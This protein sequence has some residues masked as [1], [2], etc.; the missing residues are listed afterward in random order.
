MERLLGISRQR[1]LPA[2]ARQP[3]TDWFENRGEASEPGSSPRGRV[4]LFHDTWNSYNTPQVSMA[5]TELLEAAGYQVLLPG[6]RCCGRPMISKGLLDEARLAALD[7]VNRLAP[8]AEQG[9]PILG[10]EP[11][12]IL[13]LRDEYL[14]LLPDDP[15]VELVAEHAFTFEEFFANTSRGNGLDLEFARDA[16]HLL[17][18]GHCHEKSLI[19]TGPTHTVLTLPPGHVVEEI[20]SGCCGMAGAFGYESEHYEI[21]MRM[22]ER[23][24]LPAIRDADSETVIVA[25]GISCRQ[26]IEHGSGRTALHPAEVL[27]Q[28]LI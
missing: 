15:R 9:L 1:T 23:S 28:A 17:L 10:L 13:T 26:Q 19:G 6:H 5:A 11:S 7:T 4:A 3:F 27:R 16:R 2:F 22:A 25:S 12:C 18:H 14:Y 8:L 24:L 20:D 21:S